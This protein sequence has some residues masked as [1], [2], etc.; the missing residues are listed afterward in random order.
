MGMRR[1][2]LL[3][4]LLFGFPGL[5]LASDGAIPIWEPTTITQSGQYILTRNVTSASGNA[6]TVNAPDVHIDVHGFTIT[7]DVRVGFTNPAGAFS[8]EGGK[9]I[10]VIGADGDLSSVSVRKMVIMSG[11]IVVTSFS[12]HVSVIEGNI[13]HEAW[14]HLDVDSA[15]VLNNRIMDSPMEG[16][17]I[18]SCIGCQIDGNSILRAAEVGIKGRGLYQGRVANNVIASCAGNGLTIVDTNVVEGNVMTGNGGFGLVV[19]G[20][21]VYRGNMARGNGGTGCT[22]PAGNS[23]FCTDGLATSGGNNFMPDLR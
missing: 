16:I 17:D 21:S 19:N 6:I 23:D 12:N 18:E 4:S 2:F 22:N 13:L 8:I 10:G 11:G 1:A 15:V 7:G 9:L 20:N 14:I 3:G 5:L